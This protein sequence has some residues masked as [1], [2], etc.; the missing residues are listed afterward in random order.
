MHKKYNIRV[1]YNKSVH[2][3]WI[4]EMAR[5]TV[6][7]ESKE[8]NDL[9]EQ[10]AR[11]MG[12]KPKKSWVVRSVVLGLDVVV[13]LNYCE[14][15]KHVKQRYWWMN[16]IC[17]IFSMN[18]IHSVLMWL[19]EHK[20][21]CMLRSTWGSPMISPLDLNLYPICPYLVPI[22]CS[23]LRPLSCVYSIWTHY[24]EV[25]VLFVEFRSFFLTFSHFPCRI[26]SRQT[27]TRFFCEFRSFFLTFPHFYCRILS[28]QTFTRFP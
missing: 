11:H 14:L 16:L 10:L 26:L 22:Y 25:D 9:Q 3:L 28:R 12:K 5:T 1:K 7:R 19:S 18:I 6:E 15:Q 20:L 23:S 4:A 2:C 8:L 13:N 21:S 27:F 24:P 17:F